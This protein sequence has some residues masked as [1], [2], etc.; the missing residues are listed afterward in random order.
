[1]YKKP[2]AILVSMSVALGGCAT[3]SKDVT[4]AYVSPLQYQSF[5]CEQM[6]G[7]Q[8]RIQGGITHK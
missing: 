4:S 8:T 7:E 6:S 1:M 5:D 2:L 3:A